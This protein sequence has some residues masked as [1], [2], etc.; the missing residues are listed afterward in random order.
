MYYVSNFGFIPRF[1]L[2]R[3]DV[4]SAELVAIFDCFSRLF[5]HSPYPCLPELSFWPYLSNWSKV[6]QIDLLEEV[7][8]RKKMVKNRNQLL[9]IRRKQ[10]DSKIVKPRISSPF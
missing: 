1:L 2:L 5:A 7:K 4:F 9:I 3:V 6:W 8:I 10:V